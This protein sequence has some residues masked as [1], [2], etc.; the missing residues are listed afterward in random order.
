MRTIG[1]FEIT[2]ITQENIEV[3]LI[4]PVTYSF[5]DQSLPL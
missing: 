5:D 4:I 3:P 1:R 2:V